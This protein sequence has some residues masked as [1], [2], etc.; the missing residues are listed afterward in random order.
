MKE[1]RRSAPSSSTL[2]VASTGTGEDAGRL[3][4]RV[5]LVFG[6]SASISLVAAVL[7][8]AARAI[9]T[10]D[11]GIW[12][13]AYLFLVGFLAQYLLAR[14]QT[15]LLSVGL[16]GTGSPPLRAQVILWN[17]GVVAV[18]VGVFVNARLFVVLGS[19]ALLTSL[20][21]FWRARVSDPAASE[22]ALR[23]LRIRYIALILF[24]AASALVG[25]ALAWDTPWL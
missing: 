14:G 16:S 22:D 23:T 17:A 11:H 5:P 18:P 24:M 13:V 8:A 6:V 12:L 21:S 1:F 25:T 10:F 4:A 3:A 20:A 9:E 19:V 2:S 7:A 15:R